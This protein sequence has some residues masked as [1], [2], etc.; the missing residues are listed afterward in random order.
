MV[1]ML[2]VFSFH[3]LEPG[4]VVLDVASWRFLLL[5]SVAV[6]FVVNS[7]HV[8]RVKYR[9]K[10]PRQ[11][12]ASSR[13]PSDESVCILSFANECHVPR[14][15]SIDRTVE[16]C[17]SG[18]RPSIHG[19]MHWKM[20]YDVTGASGTTCGTYL[21]DVLIIMALHLLHFRNIV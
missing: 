21:Y 8:I 15:K 13:S 7:G 12:V 6:S 4:A 1:F 2:K 11:V 14:I 10:I 16:L 3:V 20:R 19:R 18:R 5:Y 17:G 9:S